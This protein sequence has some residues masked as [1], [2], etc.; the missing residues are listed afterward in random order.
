MSVRTGRGPIRNEMR[1][2]LEALKLQFRRSY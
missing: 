2:G 1:M